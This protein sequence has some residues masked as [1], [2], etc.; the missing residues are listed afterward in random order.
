MQRFSAQLG[1]DL[2]L[3]LS[4]VVLLAVVDHLLPALG[5]RAGAACSSRSSSLREG[6]TITAPEGNW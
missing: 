6:I 2:A 5:Q 4:S 3:T 1:I